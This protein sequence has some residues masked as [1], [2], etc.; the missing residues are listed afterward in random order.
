MNQLVL[1]AVHCGIVAAVGITAL[2]NASGTS[3]ARAA[4]TA[5]HLAAGVSFLSALVRP[6]TF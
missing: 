5:V 3:S 1:S 2:L 6:L 4:V